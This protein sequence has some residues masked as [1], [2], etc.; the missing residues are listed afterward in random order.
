MRLSEIPPFLGTPRHSLKAN[1]VSGRQD[2]VLPLNG[3]TWTRRSF[4]KMI[5]A[6]GTGLG[7]ASLGL[8]PPAHRALASHVGTDGYQIADTCRGIDY[9][10]S[11]SC[12]GC[13]CSKVCSAC[14]IKDSDAHKLG[15]HKADGVDYKLRKNECSPTPTDFDGWKWKKNG[16][17]GVC[18]DP[19]Y[20]CHD[21]KDCTGSVCV[22]TVCKWNIE[23]P[24]GCGC[25]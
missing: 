9:S 20:R 2:W 23:C 11:C 3:S 15:W 10:D 16:C 14:C 7:L 12:G 4:L 21:G 8:L 24:P 1:D 19:R 5:A 18:L 17:C 13:T 6:T 25:C 22:E